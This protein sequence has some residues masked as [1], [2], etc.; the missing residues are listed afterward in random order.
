[1]LK[2]LRKAKG[3]SQKELAEKLGTAQSTISM[4]ERG[5]NYPRAKEIANI[6]KALG[7]SSQEVLN[8]FN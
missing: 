2:E 4:W 7:V 5:K 6:S 3:L 8:C 1:M